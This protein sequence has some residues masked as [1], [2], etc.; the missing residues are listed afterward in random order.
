MKNKNNE[1]MHDLLNNAQNKNN[2]SYAKSDNNIKYKNTKVSNMLHLTSFTTPALES[3]CDSTSSL[4]VE[5]TPVINVIGVSL[6]HQHKQRPDRPSTSI[7]IINDLGEQKQYRCNMAPYERKRELTANLKGEYLDWP[8]YKQAL[9]FI[10]TIPNK[11]SCYIG[12]FK[13]TTTYQFGVARNMPT[14]AQTAS[15]LWVDEHNQIKCMLWLGNEEYLVDIYADGLSQ[16]QQQYYRGIGYW[17]N[18]T[19]VVEDFQA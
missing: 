16:K 8:G 7:S 12:K 4:P 2:N 13:N 19:D 9:D 14:V 17:R 10:K 1:S 18:D 11:E 15:V 6:A 5:A 3:E